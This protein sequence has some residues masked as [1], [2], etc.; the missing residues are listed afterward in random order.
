[1]MLTCCTELLSKGCCLSRCA[2][3]CNTR[4]RL[5][6]LESSHGSGACTHTQDSFWAVVIVIRHN[7]AAAAAAAPVVVV[8]GNVVLLSTVVALSSI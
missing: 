6:H 4:A 8:V 5:T 2:I 1:M 3:C 7:Q